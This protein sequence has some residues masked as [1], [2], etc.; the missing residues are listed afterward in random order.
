MQNSLKQFITLLLPSWLSSTIIIIL[1]IFTTAT[2]LLTGQDNTSLL[3]Q[4]VAEAQTRSGSTLQ[5]VSDGLAQYTLLSNLPLIMLY[6]AVGALIYLI[7]AHIVDG[8]RDTVELSET[9]GY[10]H[11]HKDEI[12][13]RSLAR[14]V[15]RVLVVFVWL[16][17]GLFSI[18]IVLPEYIVLTRGLPVV[19]VVAGARNIVLAGL[20]S[21]FVL[22]LQVV[23][24]RLYLLRRISRA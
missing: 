3:G 10:V 2:V 13:L 5:Q 14:L 4:G 8:L 6:A 9:M 20:M 23:F 18:R 24:L 21:V 11:A 22:H 17:F 12:V 7:A 15:I 1:T 19:D 16:G